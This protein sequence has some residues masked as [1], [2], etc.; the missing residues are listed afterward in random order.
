M[1]RSCGWGHPRPRLL[2]SDRGLGQSPSGNYSPR[3][4]HYR[5][6]PCHIVILNFFQDYNLDIL[7]HRDVECEVNTEIGG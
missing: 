2:R 6:P 1:V 3:S 5:S 4:T 7:K